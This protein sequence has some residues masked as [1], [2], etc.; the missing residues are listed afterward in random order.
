MVY[1]ENIRTHQSFVLRF[2]LPSI[3]ESNQYTWKAKWRIG[4]P[5]YNKFELSRET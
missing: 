4:L 5:I 1:I 3:S 2:N